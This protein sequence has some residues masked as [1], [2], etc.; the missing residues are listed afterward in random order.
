MKLLVTGGA[1]FIGG[2]FIHDTLDRHPEDTIICVDKL[3][4][5]GNMETLFPI[6]D[7]ENFHFERADV[8]D[9]PAIK[10]I[11]EKHRPDVVI[12]FAAESHVDRSID[13]PGIFLTTNILGTQVLLSAALEFGVKRYHQV[14]TDEVYGDLPL[15]RPDLLFTEETPIHTSNPY[16]AS[17]A[18]ADLLCQAY[19]R[20]Y[21]LPITISRCSNNYGPYHFPEKMIPLMLINAS[22]DKPLPVYGKGEN[23][24]DWLYVIDHC[25]AINLIVRNGTPGEVYNIGGNNERTNID[26]VKAIL[27]Q[28]GKP[29]SLI[30]YVTDRPGHDMRYGIDP[31][32]INKE[33]GWLPETKFEDGLH[34]TIE[35]YKNNEAWWQNV[36]DGEY[37][38][39][40]DK[41]YSGR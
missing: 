11:F 6:F 12:N 31:T 22:Q 41:M 29:E 37:Q 2:N 10:A 18:G 24:R 19:A 17:K 27:K 5:A 3:T 38:N 25:R 1:G 15:D 21:K 20:T 40:Y 28:L 7:Y 39:Y 36:L 35:W 16:S 33:L 26:V 14:S 4:Y 8:A 13:D 30:N 9:A 23:V 34:L 32:K